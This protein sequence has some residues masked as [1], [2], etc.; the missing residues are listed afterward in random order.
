MPSRTYIQMLL[1]LHNNG[2]LPLC[3][4]VLDNLIKYNAVLEKHP[5]AI[6]E[7]VQ[8]RVDVIGYAKDIC[9]QI[10]TRHWTTNIT[11]ERCILDSMF[12]AELI[13]I[14]KPVFDDFDYKPKFNPNLNRLAMF[15]PLV[16]SNAVITIDNGGKN[17]NS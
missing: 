6:E 7:V 14:S 5:E 2:K 15:Y 4:E 12:M 16:T 3:K 13:E 11:F 10:N 1:K 17:E 8:R 9:P